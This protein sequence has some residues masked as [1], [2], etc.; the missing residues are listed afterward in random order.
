MLRPSKE[1]VIDAQRNRFEVNVGRSAVL[2]E[3]RSTV[4]PIAFGTTTVTGQLEVSTS[5]GAV[6]L[7]GAAP[8]A[9]L[10]VELNTLSSGNSLYDA[11]LLNR[12]EARQYP[13][14][15]LE[16]SA[17]ER[18]G[19]SDRYQVDGDLTF[20]GVTRRISG[21]VEV[22][23]DRDGLLHVAGEHVFDIRDFDVAAPSVLMLRIYPDVRIQLQL[24][25]RQTI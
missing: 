13:V 18:I 7:S 16:L 17:V 6:D 12:I 20:H 3:A 15:T 19:R 24:E 9:D 2:I 1:S 11:E 25:A 22:K 21:T 23:L 5:D 4:G 10:H 14:T 8:A